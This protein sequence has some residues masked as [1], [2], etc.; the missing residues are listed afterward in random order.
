MVE[1]ADIVQRNGALDAPIVK[2]LVKLWRAQ[3]SHGT[4]QNR[5]DIDLLEPYILHREKRRE[6]PIV[7]DPDPNTIQRLEVFFNAVSLSIERATAVMIQPVLTMHREG[8][9]RIVLIG[10]RL[11]VVNKQ[12]RDVHRFGFDSLAK[13]ASEGDK[14][15]REGENMIRK[16]PDVANY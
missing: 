10:G 12:L 1:A 4:W 15:V 8:F 7:G 13:L 16:F 6:L 3:A 2:E 9:G 11:I 14:Y 5:S